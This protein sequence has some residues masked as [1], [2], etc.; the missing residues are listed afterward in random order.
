MQNQFIDFRRADRVEAG[1]RPKY[2]GYQ[3]ARDWL[4][5]PWLNDFAAQRI[6]R[7]RYLQD[8]FVKVLNEEMDPENIFSWPGLLGSYFH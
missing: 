5:R 4:A 2:H 1:L 7:S 8:V 6:S 3:L